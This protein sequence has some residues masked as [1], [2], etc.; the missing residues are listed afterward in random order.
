MRNFKMLLLFCCAIMFQNCIFNP[1]KP[2][3]DIQ[4]KTDSAIYIY[5]TYLDN[6]PISPGL[7]LFDTL[8]INGKDSIVAP[9]SRI[10]AYSSYVD[11]KNNVS[12]LYFDD[13]RKNEQDSTLQIFFIKETVLKVNTW[14]NICSKKLYSKNNYSNR[15]ID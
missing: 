9:V 10:N 8:R 7:N 3:F 13:F 5:V 14:K 1:E 6:L 4:N 15:K 2:T 11:F 12:S